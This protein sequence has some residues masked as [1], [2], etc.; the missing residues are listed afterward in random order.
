MTQFH[1]FHMVQLSPWPLICSFSLFSMIILMYDFFNSSSLKSLIFAVLI[2]L[3]VLFEWWRD[4]CRESTFQGWHSSNVVR[5]LKIG[6][7]MFICSEVLFFF[8]FFFGYF[9]LSLNPDVVFGGIWPP[10]GLM[11]VDFLSAPTLNSILLLSSGVSIT[12][13]HHSI[14]E[15][16][17][18]E[19]KMG[20]VYTV[21]LGIMFS[22]IQL[23]EYYE[24][25]FTIA[26]SPFGSMFFLATGFHGIHVLVG[27]IFIIISFVRLLNNQFSK[28]HHVGF[29]M[30]CWYWH[31][32]D[33]VWLFLFVR[34]YWMEGM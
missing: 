18:S 16:N 9:F 23:I 7:I 15:S 6:F 11:V 3:L 26:D 4:V 1:P 27:T 32:V 19:A 14:L 2:Q 20:L 33:V 34:V 21:F 30:S 29:E 10:K 8:S 13:A 17:L 25:S 28:N 22:M 31:F 5:G 24:C 12:W